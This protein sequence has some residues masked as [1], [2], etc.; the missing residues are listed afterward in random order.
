MLRIAAAFVASTANPG[1][2]ALAR[3][4]NSATASD[5]SSGLRRGIALL[6]QRQRRHVDHDLAGDPE[7]LAAGGEDPDVG[8]RAQQRAGQHG[9][10][11]V[12][13]LAVVEDQQRPLVGEVLA[14][15]GDRPARRVVLEPE[16]GEHGLRDELGILDRRELDE[17]HAIGVLAGALPPGPEG[18]LG[19][20]HA[21]HPGERQQPGR[22][23]RPLAGRPDPDGVPRSSSVRR[24]GCRHG[25]WLGWAP[26]SAE[27]S[28]DRRNGRGHGRVP[29]IRE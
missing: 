23:E 13:V 12:H 24:A 28:P 25:R 26:R 4:T 18:E 5:R 15:G 6:G 16:C 1:W 10:R 9:R 7:R 11:L 2:T 8:A 3:S 29:A 19:L 14:E 20:A 22:G 21:A 27:P 17:P